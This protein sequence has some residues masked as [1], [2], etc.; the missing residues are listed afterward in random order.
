METL[1]SPSAQSRILPRTAWLLWHGC[2]RRLATR[3]MRVTNALVWDDSG[4]EGYKKLWR[5][6]RSSVIGRH[7][8]LRGSA[9]SFEM[10]CMLRSPQHSSARHLIPC[11]APQSWAISRH[12][13]DD[14]SPP[15][16]ERPI[17]RRSAPLNVRGYWQAFVARRIGTP[18]M[19]NPPMSC[20]T[21]G[22][23]VRL[24]WRQRA[25]EPAD[26]FFCDRP[27]PGWNQWA[28]VVGREPRK[29]RFIG[30]MP[31]AGGFD[32]IR[33]AS[34]S[35]LMNASRRRARVGR[36]PATTMAGGRGCGD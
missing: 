16:G 14:R 5:S 31:M 2:R 28:E 15:L 27:A 7:D 23:F 18:W 20:A 8:R 25:Q 17:C 35:S 3:A 29:P 33:S 22:T 36:G 26:F 13:D 24:G 30:D 11:R 6:P 19:I 1:R 12:L 10:I 32:F 9:T 21:V 34:T 4:L